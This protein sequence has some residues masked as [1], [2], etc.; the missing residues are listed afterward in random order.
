MRIPR[1]RVL[2]T[3]SV[4][5]TSLNLVGKGK[6]DSS[7]DDRLTKAFSTES[8]LTT[9]DGIENSSEVD[10]FLVAGQSNA[11]GSGVA[12]ES[13]NLP[14]AT[15]YE[16]DNSEYTELADPVGP[17]GTVCEAATGSAWPAF[18]DEYYEQTDR[19][20]VIVPRAVGGTACQSDAADSAGN[21]WEPDA[22]SDLYPPAVTWTNNALAEFQD[23]RFCGVLWSQGE[24]DAYDM[25]SN[26]SGVSASGYESAL[27]AI[28]DGFQQDINESNDWTFWIFQTGH[29]SEVYGGDSPEFQAIRDVQL[30]VASDRADTAMAWTGAKELP[31]RGLMQD[32]SHYTQEGYNEM[33]RLGAETIAA[34]IQNQTD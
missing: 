20:I 2:A 9:H 1:R 5:I 12:A 15:A 6:A 22:D 25:Q 3:V 33:G 14:D 16:W 7:R 8:R 26:V 19:P 27:R 21:Y 31:Q 23:A 34:T 28:I 11:R 24:E 30:T 32:R 18:V 10:V 17:D 29:E 4:S 13:P